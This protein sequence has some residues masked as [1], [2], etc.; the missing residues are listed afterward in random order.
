MNRWD[1]MVLTTIGFVLIWGLFQFVFPILMPAQYTIWFI[2]V[3]WIGGFFPDF[4][5]DWH[6]FLGHRS[7]LTHSIV[8]PLLIV[9][10]F[11]IPSWFLGWWVPILDRNVIAT[12][13]IAV[14]GHLILDLFPS[15]TSI[16]NRWL[17]NPLKAV[18]YI[19]KG[20]KTVPGNI[21]RVPKKYERPWLI[22]HAIVLI[23]VAILVGIFL[24]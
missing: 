19:E 7:F 5:S 8:A 24:P 22:V 14:A 9:A 10:F 15:S 3:A 18:E 6:P 21:T 20:K 16:I 2:L 12:F 1:H 11:S 4:D 13:L 23:I 17:E